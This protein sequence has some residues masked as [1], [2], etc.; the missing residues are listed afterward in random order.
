MTYPWETFGLYSSPEGMNDIRPFI[1]SD[2]VSIRVGVSGTSSN[3]M[4]EVEIKDLGVY[5]DR[6]VCTAPHP[7]KIVFEGVV[8]GE[9]INEPHGR[10]VTAVLPDVELDDVRVFDGHI[11][12][13]RFDLDGKHVIIDLTGLERG[14][15]VLQVSAR[16]ELNYR[17]SSFITFY[18]R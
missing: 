6:F 12:L 8:E 10:Y 17:Y 13:D 14:E 4:P 9:I 5:Y 18:I 3:T 1:P 7:Q 11:R 2:I 16:S 15:H